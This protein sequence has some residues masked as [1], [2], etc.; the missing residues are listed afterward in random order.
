MGLVPSLPF[1]LKLCR[2][3]SVATHLVVNKAVT[4]KIAGLDLNPM[5]CSA[6]R[7]ITLPVA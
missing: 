7:V 2:I 4:I 1:W 5:E 6:T 3:F